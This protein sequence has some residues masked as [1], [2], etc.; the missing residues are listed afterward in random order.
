ML[1]VQ[2]WSGLPD[3]LFEVAGSSQ[4]AGSPALALEVLLTI[5]AMLPKLPDSGLV[6]TGAAQALVTWAALAPG[7]ASRA[8]LDC[9]AT[10]RETAMFSAEFAQLGKT[11]VQT[12]SQARELV[13]AE[14]LPDPNADD[15]VEDEGISYAE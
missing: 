10:L 14:L 5:H 9:I 12:R 7:L 13:K 2:H 15:A 4:A 1:C 8:A 6:G 11:P 3:S